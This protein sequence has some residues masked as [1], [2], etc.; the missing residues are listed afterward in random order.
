MWIEVWVAC[1]QCADQSPRGHIRVKDIAGGPDGV[2]R[3]DVCFASGTT[4]LQHAGFVRKLVTVR[5]FAQAAGLPQPITDCPICKG[6][7]LFA[8][9]NN[10]RAGGWEPMTCSRCGGTGKWIEAVSS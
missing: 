5:E 3:C 4:R 7:G 9:P 8:V 6:K 2:Y 10:N 1:R